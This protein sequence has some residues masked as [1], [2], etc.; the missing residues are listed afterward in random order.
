MVALAGK[1]PG[2]GEGHDGPG[3]V[4]GIDAGE[5]NRTDPGNDR[6]NG[7]RRGPDSRGV[8]ALTGRVG[9]LR[10][11]GQPS[12]AEVGERLTIAGGVVSG[13]PD[14]P[15]VNEKLAAAI[16]FPAVSRSPVIRT[17]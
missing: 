9:Q 7:C 6:I 15:V 11:H 16:V 10:V 4:D 5:L 12:G 13:V 8:D 17:A 14:A 2:D 3:R 1:A